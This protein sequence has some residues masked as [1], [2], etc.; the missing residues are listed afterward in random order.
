VALAVFATL[1]F[2]LYEHSPAWLSAL[3][4][5]YLGLF[6]AGYGLHLWA[7]WRDYETK[8]LDYRALAEALRIQLFWRLAGLQDSVVD[9][10]LRRQRGELEWVRQALRARA[11]LI[12]QE[13]PPPDS[14]PSKENWHRID[15]VR[16]RWVESE[17]AYYTGAARRD[18]T[19][20]TRVT[21]VVHALVLVGMAL[22]ITKAFLAGDH[23]LIVGMGLAPALAALLHF[24][25]KHCALS[26][27]AHAYTQLGLLFLAARQH[28]AD[29][30]APHEVE[31][32]RQRL[33]QLGKEA[34]LENGDWVLLHRERPLE[35]PGA[36]G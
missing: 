6:L 25:S 7:R 9:H 10:Y 3:A 31:E 34:L 32:A 12:P 14:L 28:L 5:V 18:H 4:Y 1:A 21:R 2:Y 33:L 35:L 22:A 15:L 27:H 16:C 17:G 20:H 24:Y 11:L 23:P 29:M 30:K 26:E 8:Y 13:H 36:E 19:S